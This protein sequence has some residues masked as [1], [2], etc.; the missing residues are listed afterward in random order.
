MLGGF[1]KVHVNA[2]AIASVDVEIPATNLAHWVPKD[3][4]HVVDSGDY[5]V[6]VC[7]DSRGLGIGAEGLPAA[8]GGKCLQRTVTLLP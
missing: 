5:T 2:G 1:A 7:H 6:Y 8:P 4:G 3:N